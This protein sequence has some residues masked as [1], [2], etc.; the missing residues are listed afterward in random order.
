MLYNGVPVD[1]IM[2]MKAE[3][4]I[5]AFGEPD[6][7]GDGNFVQILSEDG[8][9]LVAMA[10]FDSTGRV[11]YF[12][13]GPE[14]YEING[15]NLN[16]DY[17]K[18]VE[19]FG[20]EPDSE[21]MF[22]LH[23]VTWFYDGY[24]ILLGLDEDGLPGKAEVWKDNAI[25]YEDN[26]VELDSELIGRWRSYDGNA[27]TLNDN[28]TV[29][30]VFSFWN[31]LNR[32]PDSVTWEA[33]NGRLI[34]NAHRDIEYKY[35][36]G[37]GKR[38]INGV[39]VVTDELNLSKSSIPDA[40]PYG[41]Y[42]REKTGSE[43]LLGIWEPGSQTFSGSY[44]FYADG[45]GMIGANAFTWYADGTTLHYSVEEK[46]AFDYTVTGDILTIFFSDGSE[47]YTRVGN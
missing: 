20:R 10:N 17:D 12:A 15:Q 8:R 2:E 46:V 42:Y 32:K 13:G 18:L 1:S 11:S 3:D 6:E 25:E 33:S 26:Q 38:R 47:A 5:A 9:R 39:D 30:E 29:F 28:G 34:L 36:I 14:N 23:E 35:A 24:S 43:D 41:E 16:H 4:V 44:E 21:E 45:T 27:L 19:I 31:S 37:E 22:D 7:Y 40:S